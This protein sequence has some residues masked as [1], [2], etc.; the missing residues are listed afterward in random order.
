M[1]VL[2]GMKDNNNIVPVNAAIDRVSGFRELYCVSQGVDDLPPWTEQLASFSREHI[3]GHEHRAPGVSKRLL[4][5]R[6]PTVSFEDLL[7]RYGVESLDALQ[8]DAEGM[9]AQLLAWFPFE[10]I[11]PALLHYDTAHM[12][13]E[14]RRLVCTRLKDFGYTVRSAGSLMD[15]MAMLF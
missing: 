13:A 7:D 12:S 2:H 9:D 1:P 14:E 10:R 6:V 11:K 15:D 4:M 3:L 8:I 5:R